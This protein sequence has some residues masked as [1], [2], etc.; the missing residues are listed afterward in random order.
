MDK[1]LTPD[2]IE[3]V[4]QTGAKVAGVLYLVAMALSIFAES[5]VRGK[6]IIPHD[7][8]RTAANIL[9]SERFFRLGIVSDLLVYVCDIALIWGLYVVLKYVN[10]N[11]ALL[12]VFFRLIETAVLATTTLTA[13]IA[14]RLLSGADFLRAIDSDQL[15]ALARAFLSIYGVGLSV[16]FVFLGLGSTIFSCLWLRSGYIPRALAWLGIFGSLLLSI[17]TLITMV[18]PKVWEAVGMIYMLPMGLYEVGLGL[19]LIVKGLRPPSA[20]HL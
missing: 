8:A 2:S 5:F 7:A 19:W 6:M 14:L 18:F 11:V 3:P 9:A 16:G 17:M 13:F 15:Q 1:Q 4:Q 12:A 10:K 20:T